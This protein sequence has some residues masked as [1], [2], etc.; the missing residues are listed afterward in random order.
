LPPAPSIRLQKLKQFLAGTDLNLLTTTT[1]E[2]FQARG[3]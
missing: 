3:C 2:R 1:I